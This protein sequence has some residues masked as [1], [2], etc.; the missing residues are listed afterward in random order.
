MTSPLTK[1]SMLRFP[2]PVMQHVSAAKSINYMLPDGFSFLTAVE[3]FDGSEIVNPIVV[4]GAYWGSLQT[5]LINFIIVEIASA[6]LFVIFVKLAASQLS[7]L[8]DFVSERVFRKTDSLEA[9]DDVATKKRNYVVRV[10]FVKLLICLVV[11]AI[12]SSSRLLP[13][14]GE[15]SDIV[16]AP[17]AGLILRSLYG[18]NVIFALEVAEEILPFT[19]V[20]PLATICWIIDT[21]FWDAD[22]ARILKL[23]RYKP[24]V[25]L[26]QPNVAKHDSTEDDK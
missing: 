5:K 20:L 1:D 13:F 21:F 23:G 26:N 8:G 19:D 16:W 6:V 10:D 4:S 2:S 18:S 15:L 12:G 7:N 9:N 17:I 3:V 22:L 14:I 25:Y 11:D 24:L